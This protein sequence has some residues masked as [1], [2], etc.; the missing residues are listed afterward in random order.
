M[1]KLFANSGEPDQ[2]PLIWVYVVYQLLFGVARLKR[3]NGSKSKKEKK[4]TK[5]KKIYIH[6]YT[7]YVKE[8]LE[9][10]NPRQKS[11]YINKDLG[12]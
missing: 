11:G 5:T 2:T 10:K 6:N 8:K 7:N 9:Q 4:N 3:I 12:Q 1:A